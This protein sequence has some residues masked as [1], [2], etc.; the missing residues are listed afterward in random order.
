MRG[1][2]CFS[3]WVYQ[4]VIFHDMAFSV[5]DASFAKPSAR[6]LVYGGGSGGGGWEN[7]SGVAFVD[8]AIAVMSTY[9]NQYFVLM[10]GLSSIVK[11]EIQTGQRR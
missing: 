9:N 7:G 1:G 2:M 10:L 4:V 6:V 11:C 5:I 8:S 3:R